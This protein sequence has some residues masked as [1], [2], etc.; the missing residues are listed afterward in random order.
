MAGIRSLERFGR[1]NYSH[2]TKRHL[3]FGHAV[4]GGDLPML[5]VAE[6]VLFGLLVQLPA[7]ALS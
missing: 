1:Q 7:A 3:P 4:T 6:T 5:T 2:T